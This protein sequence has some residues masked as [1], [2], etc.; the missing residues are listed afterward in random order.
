MITRFAQQIRADHYPGDRSTI[1][2]T[3][4]GITHVI[5]TATGHGIDA[6]MLTAA[7]GVIERAIADG[8]GSEGLARLANV[9]HKGGT[10]GTA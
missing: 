8:Y 6:A 9:L 4:S 10:G 1:A 7:K 3:A 5:N 2:S